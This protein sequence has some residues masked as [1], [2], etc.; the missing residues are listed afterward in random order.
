M[1][2]APDTAQASNQTTSF[3][4]RDCMGEQA[5][6]CFK[7]NFKTLTLNGWISVGDY[8]NTSFIPEILV[9]PHN[10]RTA[11]IPGRS[12]AAGDFLYSDYFLS[13]CL[14]ALLFPCNI[15]ENCTIDKN[16]KYGIVK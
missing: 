2:C 13:I 6:F 3:V 9:N 10:K 4:R 15:C 16:I 5:H 12:A 8:T 11:W 7:D 1:R 14:K